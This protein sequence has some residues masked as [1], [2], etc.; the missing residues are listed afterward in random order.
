MSQK[1][2]ETKTILIVEDDADIGPIL[3]K[4]ILSETA[5]LG[6]LV[7]DGIRALDFVRATKPALVLLDYLL[8]RMNGIE[9]YD[10]LRQMEAL[11]QVPIL[12][13]SASAPQKELDKRKL[14]LIKKPFDLDELLETIDRLLSH[15]G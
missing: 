11:Q 2:L 5:Y 4:V 12:M 6:V 13:M 15:I 9:V 1:Q 3:L 7:D 8:P 14:P 10:K